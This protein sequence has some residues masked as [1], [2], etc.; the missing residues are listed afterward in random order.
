MLSRQL[1]SL[2]TAL[3]DYKVWR[4]AIFHK[5]WVCG[6]LVNKFTCRVALIL[7]SAGNK[8]Y[9][10]VKSFAYWRYLDCVYS[11]PDPEV[12]EGTSHSFDKRII[13]DVTISDHRQEKLGPMAAGYVL[14]DFILRQ[15]ILGKLF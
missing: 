2:Q 8:S 6:L 4:A 10:V 5:P 1:F 12:L 9:S 13:Y 15:H 11:I 14:R 7:C 3:E